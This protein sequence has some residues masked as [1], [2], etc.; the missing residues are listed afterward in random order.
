M[1]DI[2]SKEVRSKMM[3]GIRGKNT[4]PELIIRRGLFAVGFRYRLHVK[5]LPGKPDLVFPKY[6]TVLFING[7]FWHGHDCELFKAPT[8]NR[9]FW[10]NKIRTNQTNDARN[11]SLLLAAGWRVV[12]IWECA[13]KGKRRLEINTLIRTVSN[14]IKSTS[15][16]SLSEIKHRQ[17]G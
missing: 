17:I 7:C 15:T 11:N 14:L 9:A 2:V 1:T 8:T 4:R 13:M 16:D 3:S 6:K 5:D 12:T 10:E